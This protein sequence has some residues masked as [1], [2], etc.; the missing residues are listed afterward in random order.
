[1][2]SAEE[3]RD[4]NRIPDEDR[5]KDPSKP[6]SNATD[7]MVDMIMIMG[8]SGSGGNSGKPF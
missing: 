5:K 1:L 3:N 4:N 2:Y 6:Q 8:I 7:S